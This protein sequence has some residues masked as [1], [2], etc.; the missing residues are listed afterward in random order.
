MNATTPTPTTSVPTPPAPRP[1]AVG[2]LRR[3]LRPQTARASSMAAL[4]LAS[5]GLQLVVPQ[6]LRVFIDAADPAAAASGFL[7]AEWPLA[8]I[9]V[10][11]L[12]VAAVQQIF[13]AVAT[14]LAADVGWT[15]TNLLREDLAE[16]TLGLGMDFHSGRTSGELIERIDGDVTALSDFFSQFS[17]RVFGGMLLAVGI[18]AVLWNENLWL[19]AALTA[20]TVL[21][22]AV[23]LRTRSA[24]VPASR[25]EREASA[26]LFGFVEE[27]LAG[28][29]DVR[30]NGAAGHALHRFGAVMRDFYR[31]ARRAWMLRSLIWLSSYGLFVVGN[32][33]TLGSSIVLL[34]RG[35]LTVGA[36]YMVMQYLL[37]LQTPVEQVAQQLQ[38]VQ[39]AVAGVGRIG[40]LLAEHPRVPAGGRAVPRGTVA[41][42]FERVGFR[43]GGADRPAVLHDVDLELPAGCVLG[44]LGRTGSGKTTLTRLLARFYDPTEGRI[45]LGG[46]DL[47][48]LDPHE[49]RRTVAT[50]TQDVQLFRATVRDNLTFFDASIPD[51]R[52]LEVLARVDLLPWLERLPDGL[53]TRL[54]AAGGNLSAGE[55]QLLAFARVFLGDPAVVILDEPSSRLDPA[56]ERRLGRAVDRLLEGR[57]AIVIAHRLET[58]ERADRIAVMG[59]GRLL[60]HGPRATLAADASSRYA[61]LLAAGDDLDRPDGREGAPRAAT[62]PRPTDPRPKEMA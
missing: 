44:L 36:A 6:L 32:A 35:A 19:G 29:D 28:L 22:L 12:V 48:D 1:S 10:A 41:V 11:F 21:Q 46:V 24:G 7:A 60:E 38:E 8:R 23:L 13:G 52:I 18:L 42:R 31:Q 3:Y 53:D 39:K 56:T 47:R 2:L 34:Q 17:V 30:A 37:M 26:R 15:A 45:T 58:V 59:D 5:I 50:V 27:R 43:Y 49:L 61:R 4:L 9:A 54:D 57:T 20:F 40:D 33:V 25:R 16:H 55:A 14:V 62:D 51:A